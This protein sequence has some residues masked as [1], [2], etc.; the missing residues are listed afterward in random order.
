[1]AFERYILP[2]QIEPKMPVHLFVALLSEYVG[3]KKVQNDLI[4]EIET[5]LGVTLT[6]EESNDIKAVITGI[7]SGSAKFDKRE[8]MDDV[9]RV[10]VLA[11]HGVWY[12]TRD[13]LQTRLGW[14]VPS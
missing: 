2:N 7:N 3:G 11:E 13:K 8:F 5:Y 4:S 9:Y 12:E 6:T 1:M 10:L 14:E